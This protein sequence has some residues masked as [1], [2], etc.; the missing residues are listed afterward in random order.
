MNGSNEVLISCNELEQ[1]RANDN[2]IILD[3]RHNLS[4]PGAGY[5][6]YLAGHIPAARH[7]DLDR[8]LS[9]P[10]APYEGRHPLPDS[11]TFV[12]TLC[13]LGISNDSRV[14]VYDDCGGAFAARLWWMLRHWLGHDEVAVLD[15]GIQAWSRS[16][17][18]LEQTAAT[19]SP[20][21]YDADASGADTVVETEDLIR[22]LSTREAVLLD[23]RAAARFDGLT[24][25]IDPVAGHVPGAVNLPFS[26]LLSEDGTFRI[27]AQLRQRFERSLVAQTAGDVV[28]MCG[29][30]VTACHLLLGME[31]AGLEPGKLYVGSWSEWI[32][33]PERPT[34]PPRAAE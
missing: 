18:E 25:P 4:E 10:A 8:D 33:D 15:G 26:E 13:R 12:A 21:I 32:R 11:G 2:L 14:V 3:C 34:Q 19:W 24:E 5:A 6:A 9:R 20:A 31:I 28:T 1:R 27:P 30:G 29:S 23:A 22:L 7:V 16:D 17:R